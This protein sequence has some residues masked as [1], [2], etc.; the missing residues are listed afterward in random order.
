MTTSQEMAERHKSSWTGLSLRVQLIGAGVSE[1]RITKQEGI[2]GKSFSN[3][4]AIGNA[5]GIT[6]GETHAIYVEIDEDLSTSAKYYI[7][8]AGI[9]DGKS[10]S[11]EQLRAGAN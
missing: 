5:M 9:R 1:E 7:G 10:Y 11:Y 2:L 6:N 8:M 4:Y 3:F